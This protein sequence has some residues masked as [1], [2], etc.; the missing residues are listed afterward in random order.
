MAAGD[1][2]N[3]YTGILDEVVLPDDGD[4]DLHGN[5]TVQGRYLNRALDRALEADAGVAV[6][7][8]H[9][10]AVGRP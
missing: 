6:L 5:V 2:F 9:P 7:H 3:R 4:R 10:G 1:G 8:S